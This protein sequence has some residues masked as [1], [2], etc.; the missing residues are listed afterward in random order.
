M[1]EIEEHGEDK[2]AKAVR[3]MTGTRHLGIHLAL[4]ESIEC[5]TRLYNHLQCEVKKTV[6]RT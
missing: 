1:V 2:P 5:M 4:N 3:C 6:L